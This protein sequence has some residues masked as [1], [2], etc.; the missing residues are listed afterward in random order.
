MLFD[1][2]VQPSIGG[3]SGRPFPFGRN[4]QGVKGIVFVVTRQ[5]FGEILKVAIQ[6][7]I[8]FGHSAYPGESVRI[9]GM[10]DD[11]AGVSVQRAIP[12][13]AKEA[14]LTSRSC[15]SFDSV[16]SRNQQQTA[17]RR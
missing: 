11:R 14:N 8:V 17:R 13:V 5:S 3:H 7:D 16:R 2:L 9:E 12:R 6:I 10:D 4:Q 15:E 1:E